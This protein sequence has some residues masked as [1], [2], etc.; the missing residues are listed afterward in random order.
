[1]SDK[2]K[3]FISAVIYI[4]NNEKHLEPFLNLIGMVLEKNFLHA[5]I[6]CVNDFSKD[7][8][9]S[10]VRNFS[11][12]VQ[13]ISVSIVNMSYYQGVELSMTA[14]VDLAIGDF[15]FEFD[16]IV[17]DFGPN[18][19]M[20]VYRKALE[21]FDIVSA[22]PIGENELSSKVF[23]YLFDQF[24][25]KSYMMQT[26]RFRVLSRR[27]V[28]RISS[29]NKMISYRKAIYASCGLPSTIICY[30][31]IQ[32]IS[33][34]RDS[35]EKKYRVRLAVDALLLFTDIGYKISAVLTSIMVLMTALMALYAIITYIVSVPVAG[36][37]TTVLFF[38]FAF[39]G[40]FGI[41][42]LIIKYLQIIL[43]L[44]FQRKQYT[45]ESIE[46]LTNE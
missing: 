41:L 15:I 35:Q 3:N 22:A 38:S 14:G 42:T 33:V 25:H 20:N 45:F 39:F 26:E 44:V 32:K 12:K 8:S 7:E 13:D 21:G 19:I 24:S 36:W 28:N 6:I 46:K 30:D 17:K 18:V 31:P 27:S 29:M 9:I 16:N 5:E 37:T 1:M 2:E 40:L 10:V 11:K 34:P 23:Y 4:H 43:K